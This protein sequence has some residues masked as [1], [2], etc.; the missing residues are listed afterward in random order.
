M[1]GVVIRILAR[2]LARGGSKAGKVARKS[3]EVFSKTKQKAKECCG[4]GAKPP[5]TNWTKD[6]KIADQMKKRGWDDKTVDDT[7]NNP[8]RTAPTRDTRYKPD[9]S[10]QR[11]ND[12]ATAYVRKDGSY[13]VRNDK[14]GEIVQVSNRNDPGWKNPF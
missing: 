10:G 2:L 11:N 9:G 7:I 4:K 13:V 5:N 8:H 6:K 14:T 3:R 1:A 12:P